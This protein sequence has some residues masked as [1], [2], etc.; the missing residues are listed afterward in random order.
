MKIP[1]DF[2]NNEQHV[3]FF[4]TYSSRLWIVDVEHIES[5]LT[6]QCLWHLIKQSLHSYPCLPSRRAKVLLQTSQ[7]VPLRK[8]ID[9]FFCLFH[10]FVLS[11]VS[12]QIRTMSYWNHLLRWYK[13]YK[14]NRVITFQK[15]S[16]HVLKEK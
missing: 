13:G 10:L 5:T 14:V 9:V 8:K 6:W 12:T 2:V 4:Y 15:L 11:H 3:R 7:T 1:Q 16:I